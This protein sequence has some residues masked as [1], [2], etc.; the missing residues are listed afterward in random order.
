VLGR[1]ALPA[2]L[3]DNAG[4]RRDAAELLQPTGRSTTGQRGRIAPFRAGRRRCWLM[5]APSD[6]PGRAP[7]TAARRSSYR[8]RIAPA[9]R[10]TGAARPTVAALH[11]VDRTAIRWKAKDNRRDTLSVTT[12][13][14]AV[15]GLPL[16][17]EARTRWYRK[18]E[19]NPSGRAAPRHPSLPGVLPVLASLLAERKN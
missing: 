7:A 3:E 6:V 8:T 11:L 4:S 12:S 13:L 10:R 16:R 19:D 18:L 1:Y 15:L 9:G 5:G 17:G 14:D 2:C